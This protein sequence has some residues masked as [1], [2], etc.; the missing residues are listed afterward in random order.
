MEVPGWGSD[1]ERRVRSTTHRDTER[2]VGTSL[3][4]FP[5][6]GDRHLSIYISRE[7]GGADHRLTAEGQQLTGRTAAQ[8]ASHTG[9]DAALRGGRPHHCPDE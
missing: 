4:G 2:Y 8:E 1:R 9:R 3:V 5:E 6:Q 7:G